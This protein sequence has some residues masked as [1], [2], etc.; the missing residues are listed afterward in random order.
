MAYTLDGRIQ[1]LTFIG[2]TL[3]ANVVESVLAAS[4]SLSTSE[5]TQLDVTLREDAAFTYLKSGLFYAGTPTTTGSLVNYQELRLEV[6]RVD[7]NPRGE[8]HAV[9]IVAR[10]LGAGKL[11]RQKG[12]FV[13]KNI[14]PTQFAAIYA[15][16]AG[17][18][19]VGE[20]SAV[21]KAVTRQKGES[22]WD[23]L[24]RLAGGL[25]YVC[26]ESAGTLYFAR[27]LYII[28]HTNTRQI[29]VAWKGKA[30]DDSIDAL[31]VCG[32]SGDDA[33]KAATVSVQLRGPIAEQARAGMG[34]YLSGIPQFSPLRYIVDGVTI[35]FADG[36]PVTVSASTPI[37]PP[38]S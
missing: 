14:S 8:D 24:Q 27:P 31:P 28:N 7:L 15:K 29:P 21:R 6:R 35:P 13:R 36:S 26:F 17:L 1:A 19:F 12:A 9:R 34:L 3:K 11:K 37:T 32:R 22:T 16:A 4:L 33:S 25:R 20:P 18:K 10:S 2:Q 23:A 38:R 5:V 30:T